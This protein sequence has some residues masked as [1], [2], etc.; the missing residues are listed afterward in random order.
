MF[1]KKTNHQADL[2]LFTIFDSKTKSYR[3]PTYAPNKDVLMREILN[4]MNDPGQAKN[5]LFLNA[6]DFSIFRIG[7]YDRKTGE[8]LSQ[9]L[10]HIANMHDLRAL[11]TPHSGIVP[12]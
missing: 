9:N 11:S 5:P 6:E 7:S 4:M 3:E 2:E 12:T 1:G 10:E 8:L